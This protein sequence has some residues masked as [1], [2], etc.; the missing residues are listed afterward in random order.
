MSERILIKFKATGDKGLIKSMNALAKAQGALEGN[1]KLLA[2]QTKKAAKSGGVLSTNF[3]RN[4]KD[5]SD[6]SNA[7]STI[8]SKML[9]FTF[10]MSLGV[11]QLID[12]G[13]HAAKVDSM[14]R[15]FNTLS[16]GASKAGSSILKIQ[17][18][19]LK[20]LIWLKGLDKP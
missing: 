14:A 20:C 10:A 9:L 17:T 15:A 3:K 4:Q 13:K 8:R 6:L 1:T 19:W 11:R 18:K 16:G 7:F 5:A 2:N 12:F